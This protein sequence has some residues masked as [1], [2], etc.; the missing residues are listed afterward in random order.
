MARK[1]NNSKPQKV[2]TLDDACPVD[3]QE[4]DVVV[5]DS[6]PEAVKDHAT[7]ESTAVG[8]E[9]KEADDEEG[10][11]DV[12]RVIP[13]A[14]ERIVC[15]HENCKVQAVAVWASSDDLHDEWPLC[16]EC[17]LLEFG[18]WPEGVDPIERACDASDPATFVT[19][20]SQEKEQEAGVG[21]IQCYIDKPDSATRIPSNLATDAPQSDETLHS[22]LGGDVESH[23]DSGN[24]ASRV[25]S[26][27][28]GTIPASSVCSAGCS[29]A[30]SPLP[31]KSPMS[32]ASQDDHSEQQEG[33]D[34]EAEDSDDEEE[35]QFDLK[36]ILSVKKIQT[37]QIV[38][39]GGNEGCTLLACSVWVSSVDTKKWYYCV[40]CQERDFD[41]WPELEEFPISHMS[42]S[43][44]QLIA[45]KCSRK[46][47]PTMPSLPSTP[48]SG[49][50]DGGHHAFSPQSKANTHFVTPPPHFLAAVKGGDKDSNVAV[51]KSNREV[52]AKKV[53]PATGGRVAQNGKATVSAS[54]V[55][56]HKKWQ[57]EAERLGSKDTRIIIDRK[58]A[59]KVIFDAVYDSFCPTNISDLYMVRRG[60][61]DCF[62]ICFLSP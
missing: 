28:A 26:T 13:T 27:G 49:G 24:I 9:E 46:R 30:A 31:K 38:C 2:S 48:P 55:A 42:Q 32:Q 15:R 20:V 40:D 21:V 56:T 34:E 12:V 10:I 61:E 53:T 45:T 23:I 37:N 41:G 44:M 5:E 7:A 8:G 52:A 17:Q 36:E 22:K 62:R 43:H 60:N 33:G 58:V 18:G 50:V 16:E 6:S 29:P 14:E 54:A 39:S 11:W 4:N 1:A 25:S 59:K 3:V 35:E 47:A 51:A 57:N 19:P